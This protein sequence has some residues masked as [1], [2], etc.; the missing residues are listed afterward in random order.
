MSVKINFEQMSVSEKLR[1]M[2]LLW[3]DLC[4]NESNIPSPQWHE[5]ILIERENLV[6]D[7]KDE[8][9]DWDQAKKE[10][11]IPLFGRIVAL[12]DVYDALCSRRCYKDPWGEEQIIEVIHS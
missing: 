2:E 9:I 7:G 8:F 5:R 1:I 3:D 4:N 11:E 6:C 10:K 12:A